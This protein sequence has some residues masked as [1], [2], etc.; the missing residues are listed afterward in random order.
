MDKVKQKTT[1]MAKQLCAVCNIR[2]DRSSMEQH[3]KGKKHISLLNQVKTKKRIEGQACSEGV[4]VTG[5]PTSVNNATLLEHF[6]SF[7]QVVAIQRYE[8][9]N[10]ALLQFKSRKQAHAA[11]KSSHH[12]EGSVIVVRPRRAVQH[13]TTT[14]KDGVTN[15]I[16]IFKNALEESMKTDPEMSIDEQLRSLPTVLEVTKEEK[17]RQTQIISTLEEWLSLEFPSCRLHLFGSSVSGLAFRG[18]SD[19]DIFMETPT[20]DSVSS[21]REP[22]SSQEETLEK[23][24]EHVIDVLRRA[25]HIIRRHPDVSDLFVVSHARIPVLKFVHSPTGIKCDLTC[26]NI[27]GVQNS[28][29]LF[30]L[31]SLDVRIRPYLYAL[32]F[33]A[34]SH[35]LISSPESSLSSYALTLMAVYYLQ[36]IDPPLI[37]NVESLQSAVSVEE[38]MSC[39]GWNIS[40]KVPSVTESV[41]IAS[42]ITIIDLLIGFFRYYRNLNASEMVVC[43]LQGKLVPKIEFKDSAIS[44]KEELP[45][46]DENR[47]LRPP[48]KLSL[49]TVQ[50]PFELDFNVCFN[51]RHFELFQSLCESAEHTCVRIL[52]VKKEADVLDLL[53]TTVKTKLSHAKVVESPL[54]SSVFLRFQPIDDGTSPEEAENLV[55]SV[56]QFVGSLFSFSYGIQFEENTQIKKKHKKIDSNFSIQDENGS[57][58]KWRTNYLMTVPFDVCTNKREELASQVVSENAKSVLDR[59]RA[60]TSLLSCTSPENVTPFAVVNFSMSYDVDPLVV[61]LRFGN[62]VS[63]KTFFLKLVKDFRRCLSKS[64]E[65]HL[66]ANNLQYKLK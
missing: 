1:Y 27:I 2:V 43:P 21:D 13:Q 60:I 36:Q 64:V 45:C 35:R 29:L 38:R 17:C 42:Q 12:V 24:R 19:L 55:R 40:Y 44:A 9:E 10:R 65:N 25:S 63:T 15:H 51:F 66:I 30:A 47:D 16:E 3:L 8:T 52:D 37:P 28:K 39:N 11:L 23:Q 48:L 4:Y 59:E 49:L 54:E 34:K 14:P 31:Q 58:L 6:K 46:N 41:N 57:L 7:G 22:F 18:E 62:T 50:D 56:G 33:W 26:N 20:N 61:S 32:K 53:K 5:I